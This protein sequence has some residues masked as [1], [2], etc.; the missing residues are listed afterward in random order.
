MI[1]VLINCGR[2]YYLCGDVGFPI[3]KTTN[4]NGD[5][6]DYFKC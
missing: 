5:R 1:M 2:A 6:I 4:E 3:V